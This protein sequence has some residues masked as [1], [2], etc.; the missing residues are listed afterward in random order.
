MRGC[1]LKGLR[2]RDVDVLQRIL[3]IRLRSKRATG[4]RVIPLNAAASAAVFELRERA[5]AL[6]GGH[7]HPEWYLFFRKE[8]FSSPEP[9]KPAS[10]WPSASRTLTK[11]IVC[12][13]VRTD[14]EPK[15]YVFK[16]RVHV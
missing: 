9:D 10:G 4:L 1:E 8:G 5:K 15:F 2:W 14:T 11:A 6:F 3:T 7:L 16:R 12:P 13:A